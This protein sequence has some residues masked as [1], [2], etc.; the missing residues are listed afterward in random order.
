[1]PPPTGT[2]GV[3]REI[4]G[5][6]LG[7]RRLRDHA[8]REA[9]HDRQALARTQRPG[10]PERG[11]A[12]AHEGVI[13]LAARI[14]P[15]GARVDLDLAR[16]H[17]P[18]E[19]HFDAQALEGERPSAADVPIELV[20]RLEEADLAR[21]AEGDLEDVLA[22]RKRPIR[23]AGAQPHGARLALERVGLGPAVTQHLLHHERRL[24]AVSGAVAVVGGEFARDAAMRAARAG[25][26][27]D[28]LGNAQLAVGRDADVAV[29]G[30]NPL[31]GVRGR[32]G[33]NPQA[34]DGNAGSG[35][36]VQGLSPRRSLSAA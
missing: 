4:P 21:G 16:R 28:G 6:A 14:G 13:V 30:G 26:Q 34:K 18:L 10:G 27:L 36:F 2:P 1:M 29:Q 22:A 12:F 31:H 8:L 7:K 15:A 3:G 33:A 20:V 35:T 11:R 24:D 23:L 17:R 19:A 5:G 32:R 25:L 9:D